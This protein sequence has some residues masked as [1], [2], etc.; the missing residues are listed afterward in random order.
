MNFGRNPLKLSRQNFDDSYGFGEGTLQGPRRVLW[1]DDGV[2]HMRMYDATSWVDRAL[3]SPTF[4]RLLSTKGS[5]GKKQTGGKR[6]V[7]RR[8][9]LL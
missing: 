1:T 7:V 3:T 5:G 2:S 9:A 6:M 8:R 4:G